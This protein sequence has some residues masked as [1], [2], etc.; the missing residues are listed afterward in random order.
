MERG[1]LNIINYGHHSEFS[2]VILCFTEAGEF[3]RLIRSPTC[4]LIEFHKKAGNDFRLIW[5]VARV[6]RQWHVD[7]LHAR[8][9]PTLIETALAAHLAGI[10]PT[11]YS[12]HGKT[13]REVQGVGL[14]RRVAQAVGLRTYKRVVTLTNLM[15]EDL[16]AE[17]WFAKERINII[18]NGVD[19][20][21]F[22]PRPDRLALRQRYGLPSGR[23]I[24][25]NIARL[26]PVKNHELLLHVLSRFP[27]GLDRPFL[28]IV[29]DGE[30]RPALERTIKQLGLESDVRLWG[31]SNETAGLLAC[32]DVYVQASLYE[33]FSNTVLEAMATGVPVLVTDVG[34]TRD[35]IEDGREGFY[36]SPN[37]VPQLCRLIERLRVDERLRE[38]MGRDARDR[39]QKEF[40]I[41]S[42][43][44]AY[45]SMYRELAR[46]SSYQ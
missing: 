42:M 3:A 17:A 9:W 40:T 27:R 45:E 37:D 21:L 6:V 38:Q 14:L 4:R 41:H 26:D 46:M 15:R 13:A 8:G 2:H 5:N 44:D 18:A 19:H 31:Y 25:G 39:A 24:L 43:V 12:F 30:T 32:L 23:Y 29:G 33:G 28:V 10:R 20:E 34:G 35:I 16:A 7:V 22:H 1:L 36:F 11:I